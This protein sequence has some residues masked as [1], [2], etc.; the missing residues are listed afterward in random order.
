MR[1]TADASVI[2][3]WA[4]PAHLA[5]LKDQAMS[6]R[7]ALLAG[8]I[9]VYAPALWFFEAGNTLCRLFPTEA[10]KL[11]EELGQLGIRSVARQHW[12]N[13]AIRLATQYSVTFYD[14]SYQAVARSHEATLIS[15]DQKFLAK[16]TD[17]PLWMPL[18]QWSAP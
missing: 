14:A 11:L 4:L 6:V 8:E 12:Q 2:L 10:G 3:K 18:E 16:L 1:Y 15:A 5:P 13:E 7:S 9:E 17:E